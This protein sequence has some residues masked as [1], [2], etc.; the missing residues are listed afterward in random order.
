MTL[1][2]LALLAVGQVIIT[3]PTAGVAASLASSRLVATFDAPVY[4][5][6]PPGEKH[7][8]FV[9]DQPGR[10]WVLDDEVKEQTPFL[11]IK[12]KVLIGQERGLFSIA[13]AP[14]YATTRRFYIAYTN[15]KGDVEIDEYRR[16]AGNTRR[17]DPTTR[18]VV[19]SILHRDGTTRNGGQLQFGADGYLYISV[20]DGGSFTQPGAAA[21]DL[22][23]LLGKILR[24][25]PRQKGAQP[26]TIPA[27]NPYVGTTNRSEIYAFGLRNPWRFS[28]N[29]RYMAIADE[30]EDSEEE[31]NYWPTVRVKGMNFGWP[32]FEGK[33]AHGGPPGP[34]PAIKPMYVYEHTNG[35]CAVIGGYVV[36]DPKIPALKGHYLFGD[37]C[38]GRI[39]SMI[40]DA[41][42]QKATSVQAVGPVANQLTSFGV[43]P[44]GAI[45]Y[46]Q[47]GE[48]QLRRLIPVAGTGNT[49]PEQEP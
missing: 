40:P 45:Y 31:I 43:G 11:D 49:A 29:G 21:R 23:S 30:G 5:T 27:D 38:G 2:T 37:L 36:N 24:I 32:Q 17:A 44:N 47:L 20:G 12:S 13:F 19:L 10:I 6:S 46:T 4:V 41:A 9:V 42:T 7:L 33:L 22:K 14:N 8:L 34:G 39:A 16:M 18:R 26:Y 15:K 35:R 1:R 25:D 28:F 3:M 48:G